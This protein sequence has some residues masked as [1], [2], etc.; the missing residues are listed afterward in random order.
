ML[1]QLWRDLT[2]LTLVIPCYP[3][4][5]PIPP[6][7][8][9]SLQGDIRDAASWLACFQRWNPCNGG[10]VFL[11]LLI[12]GFPLMYHMIYHDIMNTICDMRLTWDVI[13]Q[14]LHFMASI[15]FRYWTSWHSLCFFRFFYPPGQNRPN[16]NGPNHPRCCPKR[17]CERGNVQ[18]T[19]ESCFEVCPWGKMGKMGKFPERL[20]V[21]AIWHVIW[22]GFKWIWVVA[23]CIFYL[24]ISLCH[25]QY[26][27]VIS[28]EQMYRWVSYCF[29]HVYPINVHPNYVRFWIGQF[30]LSNWS[31]SVP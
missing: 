12:E 30:P 9:Q 21:M 6:D 8:H 26:D 28:N 29:I 22:S 1:W 2:H 11:C 16:P 7:L 10:L 25:T 3:R 19:R 5:I 23:L 20:V 13:L 14:A 27:L 15:A 4:R 18:G 31:T 17:W 24:E